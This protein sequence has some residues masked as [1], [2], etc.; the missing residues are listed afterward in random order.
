M[1]C[2][3]CHSDIASF[4]RI[5]DIP[6]SLYPHLTIT[7]PQW[8]SSQGVCRACIDRIDLSTDSTFQSIVNGTPDTSEADG[9]FTYTLTQR[10]VPYWCHADPGIQMWFRHELRRRVEQLALREALYAWKILGADQRALDE[11]LT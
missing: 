11:G 7:C 3:V 2:P 5:D 9:T 6:S 4:T 10:E 8:Q 1:I